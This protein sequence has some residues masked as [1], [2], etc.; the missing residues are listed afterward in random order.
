MLHCQ[1]ARAASLLAKY[2]LV[3]TCP[4]TC[5]DT[6]YLAMVAATVYTIHL[7]QLVQAAAT[8]RRWFRLR[9]DSVL[10]WSMPFRGR[11][12]FCQLS[13]CD[14][15]H[16]YA[17]TDFPVAPRSGPAARTRTCSCLG[18]SHGHKSQSRLSLLLCTL[19][20]QMHFA[21]AVMA[22]RMPHPPPGLPAT[23]SRTGWR[24][25]PDYLQAAVQTARRQQI[26]KL[27]RARNRLLQHGITTYRGHT[28]YA[29]ELGVKDTTHASQPRGATRSA[30]RPDPLLPA[31][32]PSGTQASPCCRRPDGILRVLTFN[33]GGLTKSAYDELAQWLETEVIR[34]TL[35]VV[36]LQEHWRPTSE[37]CLPSWMKVSLFWSISLQRPTRYGL[38]K[39][40]LVASSVS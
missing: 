38:R 13:P 28:Y 39:S 10:R 18:P 40:F 6:H 15:L 33:L 35:D 20:C 32:P 5:S 22:D 29:G 16:G 12:P 17:R 27:R 9:R 26:Q 30:P 23:A 1:S 36:L 37:F 14:S 7:S 19:L 11:S 31:W 4:R 34:A 3:N 21:M 24:R 8:L 25:C 2:L